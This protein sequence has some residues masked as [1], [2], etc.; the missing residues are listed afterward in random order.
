[1]NNIVTCPSCG[2]TIIAEEEHS[3]KCVFDVVE[4]PVIHYYEINEGI[5]AKGV[6]GK[7]YR[8]VKTPQLRKRHLQQKPSDLTESSD[9]FLQG[10]NSDE[11]LTEPDARNS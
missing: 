3:H 1:M 9:V 11:D 7:F 5:T 2:K 4:I 10:D 6:N 8:L